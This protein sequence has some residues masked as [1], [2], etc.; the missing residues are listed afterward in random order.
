MRTRFPVL[1]SLAAICLAAPMTLTAQRDARDGEW[2]SHS[3]DPGSTKY[4]PLDEIT[5]DNVSQLRI[6]WRRP[7]IDQ[8]LSS[9]MPGRSFAGDFRSTPLMIRGVLYA[10][11]SIGLVEAFDPG[12]GATVWVQ[13]PFGDEPQHGL[14]G[15][16]TRG[17]AYWT[18]GTIQRLFLIRGEFLIARFRNGH[19]RVALYG[20]TEEV[21]QG[22]REAGRVSRKLALLRAHGL[23]KKIPRTHRYLPRSSGVQAISAILAARRASVAQLTAA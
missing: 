10:T 3:A 11:N 13:Q 16:S 14:S 18:D 1:A 4:A 19:V 12:S 22:R 21:P 23:V 6:A 15:D 7:G 8:S 5:R 9:R 2:R 20:A 17:V